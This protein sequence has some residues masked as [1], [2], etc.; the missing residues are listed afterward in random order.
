MSGSGAPTGEQYQLLKDV[1]TGRGHML[2][3]VRFR[4]EASYA[5]GRKTRSR[6][7]Y[8]AYSRERGVLL[9]GS[10]SEERL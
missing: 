5:D 6:E 4:P 2:D 9:Q 3:L 8:T 1:P 10:R 7:A